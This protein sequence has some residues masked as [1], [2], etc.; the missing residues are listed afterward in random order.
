MKE[1]GDSFVAF[2]W[3]GWTDSLGRFTHMPTGDTLVC[4]GWMGQADW[5]KAQLEWFER[6]DGSLVVHKCLRGPYRETGETMGT[7]AEIVERLRKRLG[8]AA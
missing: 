2:D 8:V 6:L 4:Q 7:A 5:D 3:C 1:A